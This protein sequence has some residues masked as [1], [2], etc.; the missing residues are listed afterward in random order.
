M[1]DHAEI[2]HHIP[3]RIRVCIPRIKGHP[4]LCRNIKD[5]AASV[6]GIHSVETNPVT[7]SVLVH[8]DRHDSEMARRLGRVL[9]RLDTLLE[10]ADPEAAS[11]ANV[12]EAAV[13]ELGSLAEEIPVLAPLSHAVE[14]TDRRIRAA[15]HDALNLATVLPLLLAGG[16]FLFLDDKS[17]P[18]RNPV[19]LGGLVAMSLHSYVVLNGAAPPVRKAS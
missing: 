17:N 12:G 6:E 19:F 10:A 18:L 2:L 3:G 14:R 16:S 7:G 1:P 5:V 13:T 11:F 4:H 8:Y 15:S 9:E